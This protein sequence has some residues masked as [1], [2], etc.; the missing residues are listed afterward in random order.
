MQIRQAWGSFVES[1][2]KYLLAEL[3]VEESRE[4]AR[5]NEDYFKAGTVSLTEL[6]AARGLL[7]ESY[8]RKTDA[9]K[10]Y[11]MAKSIYLQVTG[12]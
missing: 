11:Q 3:A 12:R 1:Y 4:N 5:L 6:L 7:Q 8:D 10:D 9:V 2:Q